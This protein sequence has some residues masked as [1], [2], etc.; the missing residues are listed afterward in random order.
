MTDNLNTIA[1]DGADNLTA[2][3][4]ELGVSFGF[5]A[6]RFTSPTT[7][8]WRDSF[9]EWLANG[10]HGSMDWL[11][12]NKDKRFDGAQLHPNTKTA[13]VVRMDYRPE[14]ENGLELINQPERAYVARYALGR[15]YHKVMRKRLKAFGKAIEELAGQHGY[16]AFVDSAP[17]MERQMAQQAGLGWLGKNTLLLAPGTGSWFFLGELMTNLVLPFDQPS[18][19][20]HCGSCNQCLV[21]CPTD[22]FV[23]PGV[24]DARKCI[25]YLTIE[26]DGIIPEELR[27][28]MGNRVYGCD[29]C[30]LVCPHNAKAKDTQ[31][32]DFAARHRL[33]TISLIEAF[34][35]TEKEF[36]TFTEGSAIRRI[37]YEQWQRNV[38]IGLGNGPANAEAIAL[39]QA[40][41]PTASN[42]L[43][44]HIEWALSRLHSK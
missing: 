22:A 14:G 24:L 8:A 38:A 40:R 34:A 37:G 9:D 41:L 10:Y 7:E 20:N 25:S 4:R 15:D 43:K 30:Q 6:V 18:T 26:Y 21:D 31:E 13:I 42:T 17:I 2:E 33:D 5:Q 32:P 3:I 19:Q 11:A 1:T 39:L 29:D 27:S 23:A 12:R 36:L 44:P 35:W 28:K 16:R